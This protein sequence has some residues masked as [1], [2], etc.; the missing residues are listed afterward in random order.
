MVKR[1]GYRVE[2]GEIE[3]ALYK[4]ARIKEAAVVAL[5]DADAGVNIV[6]HLAVHD[7]KP[8]GLIEMKRHCSENMPLY[9]IPDRFVWQPSLPKTSTDKIDYQGLKALG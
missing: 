2:L 4:H 7:G 8:P 9:M 3:A 6:A 1:R 5:P